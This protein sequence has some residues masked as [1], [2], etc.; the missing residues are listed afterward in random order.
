[1][2]VEAVP[3]A[4]AIKARLDTMTAISGTIGRISDNLSESVGL[5]IIGL[6]GTGLDGPP[7]SM[8]DIEMNIA[9]IL[10]IAKDHI[11]VRAYICARLNRFAA[12]SSSA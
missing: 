1:M 6:E 8:E 12:L 3:K 2:I 11:M 7:S 4:D 5:G 9:A 10:N